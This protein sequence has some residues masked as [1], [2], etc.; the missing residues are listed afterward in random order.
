[1][2]TSNPGR[3]SRRSR[4]AE[5]HSGAWGSSSQDFVRLATLLFEKSA[6]YARHVDGNCSV[7]TW[8]GIPMLFSALR[9]LLIELNSGMLTASQ[10]NAAILDKLAESP[11][12]VCV[13]VE[14]YPT[15]PPELR[16]KLEL[17]LDV[18]HEIIHPAH[19]PGPEKTNTPGYLVSL[20]T[21]GVLQSTGNEIDYT[22]LS[23]L[24]SHRLFQWAF[25]VMRNTADALLRIH[26]VPSYELIGILRSYSKYESV[27]V[28]L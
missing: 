10:P 5:D 21:A 18:R 24:Q 3:K 9:C 23:Q 12:D 20:R 13:I 22:W 27:D 15:F 4:V 7:Y 25:D 16:E 1:M 28:D 2:A 8:A 26:N 11:N 14:C 19:R 6:T 17:L